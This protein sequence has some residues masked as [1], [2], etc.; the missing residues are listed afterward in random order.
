[1]KNVFFII[2]LLALNFIFTSPAFAKTLVKGGQNWLDKKE[3]AEFFQPYDTY[4]GA[5]YIEKYFGT[6]IVDGEIAVWKHARNNKCPEGWTFQNSFPHE[7][8][9]NAG[10]KYCL[11]RYH[12]PRLNFDLDFNLPLDL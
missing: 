4:S 6:K 2:S 7:Q 9:N 3:I 8:D 5:K 10:V 1:M 11:K 12:L